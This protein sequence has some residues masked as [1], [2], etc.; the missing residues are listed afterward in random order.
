MKDKYRTKRA[1]MIKKYKAMSPRIERQLT[2]HYGSELARKIAE[3]SNLEF[4]EI[5]PQMPDIPGKLNFFREI[6]ETNAIVIAFYKALRASGKTLDETAGIFYEMVRDLHQAIPKPLRWLIGW[7]FVSPIFL[8]MLQYFSK[9][10]GESADGWKIEYHKGVDKQ[11]DFYFE[12]TE[13]GV[14]KFYE[15]VGVPELGVYCNFVDY[16]QSE[17]FNLGMKQLA[18]LGGGDTK[19]IEC[20]KRGRQTE[21]PDNLKKLVKQKEGSFHP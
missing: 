19:C 5:I 3:K 15:K 17:A 12:A 9:L 10:S 20:F 14:L 18:H 11:C 21:V 13:C 2:I 7:F 1:K 6:I 8:K 4:E 16:I